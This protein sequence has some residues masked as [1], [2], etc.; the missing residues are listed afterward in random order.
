MSTVGVIGLGGIGG[1]VSRLL[2]AAGHDLR[3][4][5]LSEEALASFAQLGGTPAASPAEAADGADC[6]LVAVFNDEQ[7]LD[8]LE[9]EKGVLAASNPAP[10]VV[11][12]STITI[13]TIR[14]VHETAQQR[15]IEL[16]DC[17]VSGGKMIRSQQKMAASVGGDEQAFAS[18]RPIL[19]GYADPVV[20]MGPSGAGMK[21]KIARNMLHF[22]SVLADS[23]SLEL[24]GAA[25]L[26]ADAF[27]TFVKAAD[28]NSGGRM[29]YGAQGDITGDARLANYGS[30]DMHVAL[31]LA[32]DVGVE[33]P[34][35]T[36]AAAAYDRILDSTQG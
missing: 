14:R 19:E 23:E 22:C 34:Q 17:G 11:V 25:G 36:V 20:Y 15:G 1:G 35:A 27:R 33:L 12:L 24:A 4:Y 6:V 30:K 29:G 10:V 31:N 13:D 5:D 9:S 21:A 3:G 18:V 2:A 7:A 8:V 16:L 32:A 28:A 26:D